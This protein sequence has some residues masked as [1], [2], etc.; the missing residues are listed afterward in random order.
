MSTFAFVHGGWHGAWC[1]YKTKALLERAGHA[2]LT[3]DLPGH[4]I[5]KTPTNEVTLAG[6]VERICDALKTAREP[7][8]LIGHSMGGAVIS[9]A[10]EQYPEK[11][12]RL[13][14]LAAFLLKDGQSI[15]D[16]APTDRAANVL[17]NLTFAPDGKSATFNLDAIANAFYADCDP[18]DIALARCLLVPQAI[19]PLGT[20]VR[21]TAA[22]WGQIPRTFIECTEDRAMTP[23]TQRAMYTALPCASVATLNTSHSPFFS[24]PDRLVEA[25]ARQP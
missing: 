22:K 20:P 5:D 10:G 2:V 15:M 4:G 18:L 9:Q 12:E 17:P 3:P 16:V 11:I 13:V 19:A 25:L 23:A 21:I 6:Y 7:V 14:Y 8:T 1:W 24:A